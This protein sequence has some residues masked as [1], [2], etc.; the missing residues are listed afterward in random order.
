MNKELIVDVID[1]IYFNC[2][3]YNNFKEKAYF[4]KFN[5]VFYY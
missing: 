3:G 4:I 2:A 5:A 1:I